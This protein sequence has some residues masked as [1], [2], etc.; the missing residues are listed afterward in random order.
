MAN[1]RAALVEGDVLVAALSGIQCRTDVQRYQVAP[2][3]RP[4]R[5][6]SRVAVRA[7]VTGRARRG[8]DVQRCQAIHGL[9]YDAVLPGGVTAASP[10]LILAGSAGIWSRAPPVTGTANTAPPV[11]EIPAPP[12]VGVGRVALR[13]VPHRCPALPRGV[14]VTDRGHGRSHGRGTCQGK[15]CSFRPDG[16]GPVRRLGVKRNGP[17]GHGDVARRVTAMLHGGS[18]RTGVGR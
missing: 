12:R 6:R 15:I 16:Q 18:R 3:S 8:A 2:R 4:S 7:A 1:N 10:P 11:F 5:S 13:R 17:A 14:A 9:R